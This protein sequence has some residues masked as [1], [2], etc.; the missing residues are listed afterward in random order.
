[1]DPTPPPLTNPQPVPSGA[2]PVTATVTSNAVGSIGA[3]FVAFS[4][5]KGELVA[6]AFS[7]SD[8]NMVTL[9]TRFG[10]GIVRIGGSSVDDVI[11]TPGGQGRISKQISKVDIDNFAPFLQKTGWRVIYGINLAQNTEA[12]AAEEAAYAAKMLGSSI[13]CFS[14][15]NEPAAYD[16]STY[17][18]PTGYAKWNYATFKGRWVSLRKAIMDAVP[19]AT[20]AGPDATYGSV[21]NY[22]VP[23]ANDP[24]VRPLKLLSQHYY[25]LNDNDVRT[26]DALLTTPDP[27]L[28]PLLVTV[29]SAADGLGAPFRITE[30][31][32]AT[33]GGQAGVSDV[34][35]SALWAL[36]H[37]FL[38][39]KGGASGLHF[40][41]GGQSNYT[42]FTTPGSQL[43]DIRPEFYAMVFFKMAGQG[44]VVEA[45][46]NAASGNI[47]IYSIK[48]SSG[49]SVMFVNKEVSQS[50]KVALQ[51]PVSVSR[52]TVL[53]LTGP[54]LTSTMGITIQNAAISVTT[55]LGTMDAAYSAPV[56]GQNATVY[57]PA[58]S[59]VLVKAS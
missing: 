53:Q 34:Y 21:S 18:V 24:D 15:G 19:G 42:P 9:F 51:L 40:H 25:R 4:L 48:T 35:G 37:M 28:Q 38:V 16:I 1:M 54:G 47:S 45:S 10:A 33:G 59:A 14:L 12:A 32:S 43:T 50:F 36:D 11:W 31:N 13:Y 44:S 30:T 5:E 26:M 20:F 22:T 58:L 41:S 2:A 39:A 6:R 3:D 57:V 46:F 56:S 8:P 17:P 55:G 27:K 49:M 29:K 52:A 7:L 23:F